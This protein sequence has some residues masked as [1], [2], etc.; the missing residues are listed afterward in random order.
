[1]D[2]KLTGSV[3]ITIPFHDVDP[4]R[5]VWHGHYV[6]YFEIARCE[7][8]KKIEYDYPQMAE[9]GYLWPVVDLKIKYVKAIEYGDLINVTASL[10]EYENRIK[11]QY[12]ISNESGDVITKGQTTQVA[13]NAKTQELEF[14]S[15][16]IL[17]DN[18]KEELKSYD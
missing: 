8:L 13:V 7:L 9:S 5:I 4:M 6:K 2:K 17:I 16:Q 1:M 14:C 10:I 11:I 12:R 18:V 15:P 3:S